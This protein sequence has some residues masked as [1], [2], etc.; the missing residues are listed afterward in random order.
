MEELGQD[1]GFVWYRHTLPGPMQQLPL[2]IMGLHDRAQIFIDGEEKAVYER[3]QQYDLLEFQ[4]RGGEVLDILV[5]NTGRIN[6]GPYQPD[7]KG[8]TEG[9]FWASPMAHFCIRLTNGP[10]N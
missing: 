8:I 5:E 6:Y 7:C 3:G 4:P 9:V 2:Q 10:L 1:Y